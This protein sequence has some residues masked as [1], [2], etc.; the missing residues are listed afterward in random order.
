MSSKRRWL[1]PSLVGLTGLLLLAGLW[2]NRQLPIAQG[3]A[4]APPAVQAILWPEPRPLGEFSFLTQHGETF[5]SAELHGKW[6]FVFFG[7][8]GCPDVCP[9]SLLA[10]RD[11]RRALSELDPEAHDHQF[12]FVTVDPAHDTPAR[13]GPYVE[14]FD[15]DIIGLGGSVAALESVAATLAVRYQEVHDEQ[16]AR[17]GIDH[18][19]SLLVID[20]DGRAVASFAPPHEPQR[21]AERFDLLRAYW[22]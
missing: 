9:L 3:W 18:T 20:P 1:A 8:L 4:A 17:R 2:L 12:I 15:P 13:L 10:M 19:S 16:G 21:M 14:F 22:R 5:G 6:S 11:F 7:Y